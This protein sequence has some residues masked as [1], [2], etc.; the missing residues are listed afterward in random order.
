VG[1]QVVDGRLPLDLKKNWRHF[2]HAPRFEAM[3]SDC[4]AVSAHLL[5]LLSLSWNL[6]GR[7]LPRNRASIA[8]LHKWVQIDASAAGDFSIA[9]PSLQRDCP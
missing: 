5:Y 3:G 9:Q 4:I 6:P 1:V 7:N 8:G 2:L